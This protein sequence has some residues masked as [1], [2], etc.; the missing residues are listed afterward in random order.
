MFNKTTPKKKE[1][2]VRNEAGGHAYKLKPTRALFAQLSSFKPK[3]SYYLSEADKL[4]ILEDAMMNCQPV[5]AIAL[6][7]YAATELG[8][9]LAP[10][11]V[12]A[13]IVNEHN[14]QSDV[15]D[16]VFRDV[17]VRPDMIANALGY[18]KHKKGG[19]SF[20]DGMD[21]VVRVNFR[22]VLESYKEHT[23]IRRKM[24]SREIKL[25]DLIKTLRPRP[26][27]LH[28][29]QLYKQIIEDGPMSKLKVVKDESGK[30]VKADHVT[31]VLSS[32][33]TSE[34]EK[35]Q[36]ITENVG[37]I[38]IK[39]LIA[40]AKQIKPQDAKNLYDRLDD[41]FAN[42]AK[43]Y[44]NPLD[45]L[46]CGIGTRS[47]FNADVTKVLE[48]ILDKHFH[49]DVDCD[50]PLIMFDVSGSM[51]TA[52]QDAGTLLGV[53]YLTLMRSLLGR[54]GMRFMAFDT[55]NRDLTM[56]MQMLAT[57]RP[58]AFMENAAK[59]L[60]PR[61]G[62]SLIQ[63]TTE[64]LRQQKHDG[65]IIF[66]DEQTWFDTKY[67][68]YYLGGLTKMI[69]QHGLGGQTAIVNVCPSNTTVVSNTAGVVRI[70]GTNA[71]ILAALEPMFNWDK[72]VKSLVDK[73]FYPQC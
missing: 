54:D 39:A 42:G 25:K 60:T 14:I 63:C 12:T 59:Y 23:L 33:D 65:L 10:A 57:L 26:T 4:K 27:S 40:N 52:H 44:V 56:Q 11:L 21:A 38:P 22:K 24:L 49:L 7:H 15:V 73:L 16:R 58:Y 2:I 45:I 62:T 66:T 68:E 20:L 53:R 17:F 28:M 36:Y 67:D 72:F 61:G 48:D 69:N 29:S 35:A 5:E 55:A 18:L 31:A 43:R 50:A 19:K 37:N 46:Q 71:N 6:A 41:A 64:A 1:E 13:Y 34:K 9:R 3:S 8:M 70:S 32:T 51:S 47:P 30:V